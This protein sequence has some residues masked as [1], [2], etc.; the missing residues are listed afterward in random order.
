MIL[1]D[2]DSTLIIGVPKDT[3]RNGLSLQVYYGDVTWKLRGTYNLT[4]DV[5]TV[6]PEE[7]FGDEEIENLKTHYSYWK[8]LKGAGKR[9]YYKGK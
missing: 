6:M 8:E 2:Y 3:A 9:R 5:V 7:T 4:E 1:E